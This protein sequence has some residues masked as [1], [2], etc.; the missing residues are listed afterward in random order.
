MPNKKKKP[1]AK[2]Q[3]SE[4]VAHYTGDVSEKVHRHEGEIQE[5]KR[6]IA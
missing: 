1:A 4:K 5:I 2:K 3:N 6:K